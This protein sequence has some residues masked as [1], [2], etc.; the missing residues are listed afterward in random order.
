[1]CEK[2]RRNS[3]FRFVTSPF[4]LLPP[5]PN[6][7][8]CLVFIPP[9]PP[10]PPHPFPPHHFTFFC[11]SSSFLLEKVGGGSERWQNSRS[12]SYPSLEVSATAPLVGDR[13]G[14]CPIL[15]VSTFS[16]QD[17]LLSAHLLICH[18]ALA[19][20]LLKEVLGKPARGI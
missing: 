11:F 7:A 3:R 19:A 6:R 17:P 2:V 9:F 20:F 15:S 1:M 13:A 16:T 18:S 14:V 10:H 5:R 4:P 12:L 8:V